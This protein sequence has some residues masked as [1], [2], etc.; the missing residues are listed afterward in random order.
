MS[1]FIAVQHDDP[2]VSL[3]DSVIL[4]MYAYDDIL[5]KENGADSGT[6]YS[7][8]RDQIE[9]RLEIFPE[10][11]TAAIDKETGIL[12]GT[13][14]AVIRNADQLQNVKGW[15]DLTGEGYGRTHNPDGDS[16]ICYAIQTD[17]SIH[18]AATSLVNAQREVANRL[19]T[20]LFVFTRPSGYRQF[21]EEMGQDGDTTLI[22][23]YLDKMTEFGLEMR[24][25]GVSLH[26]HLGAKLAYLLK[27]EEP[28]LLNSRPHDR[29]SV[30]INVL[31]EYSPL[32]NPNP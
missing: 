31:M 28:Y 25:D 13:I 20:R 7:T 12:A 5:K 24:G 29:A 8:L 19:E 4:Y 14:Y 15:H 26:T 21:L 16:L 11:Q 9:S 30:G 3:D 18:G 1:D 6:L 23:P 17:S 2:K 22:G 27:G 10:G 32:K